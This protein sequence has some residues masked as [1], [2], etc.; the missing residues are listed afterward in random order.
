[1]RLR[2]LI[3]NNTFSCNDE[4]SPKRGQ[5]DIIIT[6]IDKGTSIFRNSPVVHHGTL[7]HSTLQVQRQDLDGI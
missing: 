6:D 1:M 3:V 2:Y 4:H 5:N 7:L